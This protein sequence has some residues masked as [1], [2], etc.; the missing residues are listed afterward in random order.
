M[1]DA[2]T[3]QPPHTSTYL[4]V[5]QRP[6]RCDFLSRNIERRLFWLFH[7][8]LKLLSLY[9]AHSSLPELTGPHVSIWIDV[10]DLLSCRAASVRGKEGHHRA[11]IGTFNRIQYVDAICVVIGGKYPDSVVCK[12]FSSL[13]EVVHNLNSC[14]VC[15][16]HLGTRPP[17]VHEMIQ[18]KAGDLVP[19]K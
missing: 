9:V 3:L 6:L 1:L 12:R 15:D 4:Q 14:L 18:A 17:C 19:N 8:V 7:M 13:N 11:L 10:D 16:I 5:L 2:R